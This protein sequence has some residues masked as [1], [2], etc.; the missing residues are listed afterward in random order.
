MHQLEGKWRSNV[1]HCINDANL[2]LDKCVDDT[3]ETWRALYYSAKEFVLYL[4]RGDVLHAGSASQRHRLC[5]FSVSF[6]G[7]AHLSKSI[8]RLSQAVLGST[9]TIIC[10]WKRNLVTVTHY[11]H[12]NIFF[13]SFF[14]HQG[15]KSK[16][17]SPLPL[18]FLSWSSERCVSH[19]LLSWGN[20]S[21]II[22]LSLPWAL[23][24]S[25]TLEGPCA[26]ESPSYFN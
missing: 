6:I 1:T 21:H 16:K 24:L 23:S 12:V 7:T 18:C 13:L 19:L 8:L 20:S 11:P 25:T 17:P 2:C 10:F 15:Q 22:Q 4:L 14:L 3:R 9:V 5:T 26:H